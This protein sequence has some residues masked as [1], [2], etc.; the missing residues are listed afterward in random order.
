[1]TNTFFDS[2]TSVIAARSHICLENNYTRDTWVAHLVKH[3]TLDFGSGHDLMISR[4][5]SS[6]SMLGSILTTWSLFGILSLSLSLCSSSAHTHALTLSL[7]LSKVH[8]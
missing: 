4:F 3:L 1:M 2:N 7:S 5:M 8:K 6:S